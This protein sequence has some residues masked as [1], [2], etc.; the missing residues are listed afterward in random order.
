MRRLCACTRTDS[1]SRACADGYADGRA[2]ARTDGRARA[3][4]DHVRRQVAAVR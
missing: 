4:A 1:R 2:S 3:G